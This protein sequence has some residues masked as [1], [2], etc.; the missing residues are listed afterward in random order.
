[1][2]LQQPS[3][4]GQLTRC[5]LVA[6]LLVG[7][8]CTEGSADPTPEPDATT[9]QPDATTSEPDPTT[10][11]PDASESE[12]DASESDPPDVEVTPT[13]GMLDVAPVEIWTE[14]GSS[15]GDLLYV[16]FLSR[17]APCEALDRVD[18]EEDEG[19]G[20]VTV[21]LYAG[22]DPELDPD[23]PCDGPLRAQ[24]VVLP[25]LTLEV[26]PDAGLINGATGS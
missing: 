15:D 12:P 24:R 6:V 11:E 9:S 19:T 23:E 13:P 5:A 26:T 8:A 3:V 20:R 22:R 2:A 7:T 14:W 21:T 1:M 25:P 16:D 18:V 4:V 17:G 10:A